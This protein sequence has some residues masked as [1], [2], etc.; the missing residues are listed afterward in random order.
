MM[1]ITK[2]P[3][4]SMADYWM[5]RDVHYALL[6]STEIRANGMRTVA[7]A[8]ELLEIAALAGVWPTTTLHGVVASGWRPGPVNATTPGAARSSKHQDGRAIDI[9]D[10]GGDLDN[11]LMTP[12]GQAALIRIGLWHEHPAH[13]KGWAHLQTIPPGSGRRT[14]YP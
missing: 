1:I 6:L 9:D 2:E 12:E 10:D 14:F 8:N 4:I 5:G 7:L 11:W 3:L 13:T